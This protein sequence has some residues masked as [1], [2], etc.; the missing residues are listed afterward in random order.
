M[1][2]RV[3]D[4]GRGTLAALDQQGTDIR[5]GLQGPLDLQGRGRFTVRFLQNVARNVEGPA[6]LDPAITELPGRDGQS[7]RL[8]GEEVAHRSF[9]GSGSGRGEDDDVVVGLEE[10]LKV[11]PG[12]EQQFPELVLA[13]V[14]QG[15]GHGQLRGRRD[16]SRSW[17]EY[18][19][20]PHAAHDIT[21]PNPDLRR[22]S[23]SNQSMARLQADEATGSDRNS[24][25]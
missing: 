20:S 15:T 14:D 5:V 16:R 19:G 11:G 23:E 9:H 24:E 22:E 8:G 25:S 3:V 1:D 13:M 6:D 17:G 4:G 10:S 21:G 7:T 12:L 18:P 2:S